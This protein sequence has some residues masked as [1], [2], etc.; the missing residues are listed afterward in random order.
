MLFEAQFSFR[1][2]LS[3]YNVIVKVSDHY[4]RIS[5]SFLKKFNVLIH[6]CINFKRKKTRKNSISFEI[7]FRSHNLQ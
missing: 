3:K 2:D 7:Y 6:C 1:I 5:F 4:I